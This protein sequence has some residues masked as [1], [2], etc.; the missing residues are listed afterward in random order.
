MA[1]QHP[2]EDPNT[3]NASGGVSESSIK[4]N[5]NTLD[6]QNHVFHVDK[7]IQV[8]ALKEKVAAQ[9]AAL[10]FID[11]ENGDALHLVVTELS[12][13]QSSSGSNTTEATAPNGQ[14]P[15]IGASRNRIAQILHSVML[16]TFNVGDQGGG[17]VPD[18]S[19]VI[20]AVLNSVGIGSQIGGQHPGVQVTAPT[21][22]SQGNESVEGIQNNPDA[23]NQA[24]NQLP[25]NQLNQS[26]IDSSRVELPTNARGL[27]TP[28]ALSTVVSAL[29]VRNFDRSVP[30]F[31]KLL[32]RTLS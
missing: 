7:N 14:D 29:S 17:L 3:S 23:R 4:I 9:T 26:P 21:F 10:T 5:I 2:S 19:R 8:S 32:H 11:L 30:P 16:G 13:Q 25:D 24:G 12:Q 31:V 22:A 20:G 1:D 15:T 18:L 27:P 6:F 28:L